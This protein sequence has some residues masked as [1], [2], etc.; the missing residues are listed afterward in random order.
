M[1]D[2]SHC[3]TSRRVWLCLLCTLPL[4][5]WKQQQHL[6]AAE[7]ACFSQLLCGLHAPGPAPPRMGF[8]VLETGDKELKQVRSHGC[9]VEEDNHSPCPAAAASWRPQLQRHTWGLMANF[10]PTRAQM[11]FFAKLSSVEPQPFLLHGAVGSQALGL[12]LPLLTSQGPSEPVSPAL[13]L[14]APL[15]HVCRGHRAC[16][17]F[18]PPVLIP[19]GHCWWP[20]TVGLCTADCNPSSTAVSNCK[21][22]VLSGG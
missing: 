21:W 12:C 17:G 22:L 9:L 18:F 8:A 2:A 6:P 10:I 7:P 11:S 5:S 1:Y 15:P 16:W 20:A 14:T 13:S 3:H 19:E 4:G